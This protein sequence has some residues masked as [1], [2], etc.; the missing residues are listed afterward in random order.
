[1]FGPRF[2]ASV[3]TVLVWPIQIS[4]LL[5]SKRGQKEINDIE[6]KCKMEM[7]QQASTSSETELAESKRRKSEYN[8]QYQLKRKNEM[9]QSEIELKNICPCRQNITDTHKRHI[10]DPVLLSQDRN[11]T[12]NFFLKECMSW[13]E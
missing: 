8:K 9:Q 5:E 11:Y 3:T 7:Q 1:M 4:M 6:L 12:C 10:R 2:H 13:F